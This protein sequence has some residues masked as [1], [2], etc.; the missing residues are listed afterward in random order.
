VVEG[1][2]HLLLRKQLP[3]QCPV[4]LLQ[5]QKDD[6]VPWQT[7]QAIQRQ[8]THDN[9]QI[10]FIPEGDHRLSQPQDLALLWQTIE[11]VS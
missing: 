9:V 8:M 6:A 4:R 11:S 5:G 1:R 3:L 10:I 7:A 2:Q